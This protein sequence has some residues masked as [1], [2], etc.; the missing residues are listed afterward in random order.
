LRGRNVKSIFKVPILSRSIIF[1]ALPLVLSSFTHFWNL[2]GFPAIYIDEDIYIRKALRALEGLPL[3]RDMT[4]PLYGWLFLSVGLGGMGYP[5]SLQPSSDG[6]IH[7]I[8]MLY[9]VPRLLVGIFGVLDTFLIFKICEYHYRSS[10]VALIGS[11]L[12]AVMPMTWMTR[13]VLLESIQLPFLLSSL[14]FAVIAGVQKNNTNNDIVRMI[15]PI[16][17]SGIFLGLAI[18]AKIPALAMIPLLVFLIYKNTK[19]IKILGLWLIPVFLLPLISPAYANS[20]GMLNVWLDGIF[21]QVNRENQPLF[22]LSGQ[23]SNNAVGVLLRI[24]PFLL[25]A[26]TISIIFASIKR[27]FLILLWVVP[28]VAFFYLV[29]YVSFFHFIPL[30]PAFCIAF[31]KLIVNLSERIGARSK[32]IRKVLPFAIIAGVGVFGL[33]CTGMLITA[34]INSTHFQAAAIMAHHLPDTDNSNSSRN[35]IT[36]IMG[37]NRFF[38]IVSYVFHKDHNYITYWNDKF[39]INKT[40]RIIMLV[41]D[42]FNYRIRTDANKTH[43]NEILNIY[44][45]SRPVIVLDRNSDNYDHTK[46]PYTGL[47]VP[48]PGIGRVE[49]RTNPEAANLFRGLQSI[50]DRP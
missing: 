5:N 12:F 45:N 48:S 36:V 4:N 41:E 17:L 32:K 43:V 29:G 37:N 24:D 34:N 9:L 11:I 23:D 21:F 3:E 47:S 39:P 35:G 16:L 33:I 2:T 22:D 28:Y 26:G 18:F 10:K 14:L 27:D 42:N 1:L 25:I 38:W 40:G 31:A 13:Y 15:S 6:N 49:I 20:L 8:E 7:S 44:N 19:S 46:Y 30:L 50:S